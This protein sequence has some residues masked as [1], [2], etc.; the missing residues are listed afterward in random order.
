MN[1]TGR[2]V[3]IKHR[4]RKNVIKAKKNAA[5]AEALAAKE[6]RR[7]KRI[8]IKQDSPISIQ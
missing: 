2:A 3:K 5:I 8:D 7:R 6:A 4:K 1:K